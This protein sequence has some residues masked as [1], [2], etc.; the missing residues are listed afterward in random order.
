MITRAD[1]HD[2]GHA[3]KLPAHTEAWMHEK[4]DQYDD[5]H[6]CFCEHPAAK[7]HEPQCPLHKEP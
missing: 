3:P 5:R 7:A 6:T 2:R 1:S 4:A